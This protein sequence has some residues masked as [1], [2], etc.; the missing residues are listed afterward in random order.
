MDQ[1]EELMTL[2]SASQKA[3]FVYVRSLVGPGSDLDDIL[4]DVNLILWRKGEEFDG[5]GQFL[6]WACHI[7]YIQVLAH[8]KK[9]R[10]EKRVFFDEK[11]LSDLE[12]CIAG[13]VKRI[14]A[15][16]DALH[17]CLSKLPPAQ[18]QVV[19]RRYEGNGSIQQV[20]G[21]LG[22]PVG[23]VKVAV[24]RIRQ[25][26]A[27][28]IARLSEVK[29]VSESPRPA[30]DLDPLL[31]ELADGTLT[32]TQRL[33]LMG[34]LRDDP[35]A[36]ERCAEYLVLDSMLAWD[37]TD[38]K[39]AEVLARVLGPRAGDHED[40][41]ARHPAMGPGGGARRTQPA[42]SRFG[43]VG[44]LAAAALLAVMIS[45][46]VNGLALR[47]KTGVVPPGPPTVTGQGC[48]DP[49]R[50]RLDEEGFADGGPRIA[51][52][53]DPVAVLTRVVDVE[54]GQTELPIE[55][56]SSMPRGRLRVKSGL[57]QLEFYGG[58]IVVLEG[59]ADLELLDPD[60]AFCRRGKLRVRAPSQPTKFSVET[61]NA[62]VIDLGTEFGVRVDETGGADV[63][64]FEGKV[65]LLG[66]DHGRV[67]AAGREMVR[68]QGA[69]ADPSGIRRAAAVAPESFSGTR[70]LD[71]RS[72]KE[73]G[74]RYL[75]WLDLSRKLQADPR[76][77]LYYSFE[78]QQ[79]WERTLRD[80]VTGR[81]P[82]ID[83]AIVGGQWAE[84]RWP[85]KGALEF[86]RPSDRV[87]V[88][89]P[90][91]LDAMTL[92][93]WVRVDG[94][95]RKLSSL[96][97]SDNWDTPGKL[98]WQLHDGGYLRFS[99]KDGPEHDTPV[100]LGLGQLGLWT[101]LVTVLDPKD[102]S[103]IHYMNG[104][105]VSSRTVSAWPVKIG[106]AEIGNW[107]HPRP[108]DTEIIRNLNGRIDEF[109]LFN[110]ALA[111]PE[112]QAMFEIGKPGA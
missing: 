30:P 71:Q 55:A 75:A 60:R 111:A 48:R 89:V 104:R 76:V 61:P 38:G 108:S 7:A 16:L 58:A 110:Q 52:D 43:R 1:N 79:N 84:G 42:W 27:D 87:R 106:W 62:D 8:W 45:V 81:S 97:L 85:G 15:R 35:A 70:E 3:L 78:G 64:V 39:D 13:K 66:K 53:G 83:G 32:P 49:G 95:D 112:I 93:V 2:I 74:L 22:R 46:I 65:E 69:R 4:Q 10:R 9:Q 24:H 29:T 86:K 56:G 11:I 99:V 88:N 107:S 20:A 103:V 98:H 90:G 101:H 94:F 40:A 41:E 5:S 34:L 19:L 72:S 63:Q 44:T 100:I 50:A 12:E 73:A 54:W 68:G 17:E 96:L 18:R 92:M 77:V 6:T 67:A 80:Q 25:L 57:V 33:H 37:Q 26:L 82:G 28:C 14:D 47:R 59:P 109:I 105:I 91:E 31:M 23:S 51:T 36:C 102:Q 21:E